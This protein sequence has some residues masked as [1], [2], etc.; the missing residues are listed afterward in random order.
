MYKVKLEIESLNLYF[1]KTKKKH[2]KMF[3]LKEILR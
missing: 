3:L 1:I 2:L